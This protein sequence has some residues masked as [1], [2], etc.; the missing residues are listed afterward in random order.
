MRARKVRAVKYA[1]IVTLVGF[2]LAHPLADSSWHL[3]TYC[4]RTTNPVELDT[5]LGVVQ[6]FFDA[7]ANSGY[8]AYFGSIGIRDNCLAAYALLT[9]RYQAELPFE[10]FHASLRG[11]TV[12]EVLRLVLLPGDEEPQWVFA[13]LRTLEEVGSGGLSPDPVR[14]AFLYYSAL[15]AVVREGESWRIDQMEFKAEDFISPRGGH[16]PW[17]MDPQAVAAVAARKEIGEIG[18][19]DPWNFPC[20]VGEIGNGLVE[21]VFSTEG[22]SVAILL[23]RLATG[24]WL[25]VQVN[26]TLP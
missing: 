5:P 22:G 15:L 7:L 17:R 16:Q 2:C 19:E 25:P 18:V 14:S 8:T 24:N 9:Q 23:V 3:E 6:R 1:C 20:S 26:Q 4:G 13:E 10:Q 21:V 11:V 12:L